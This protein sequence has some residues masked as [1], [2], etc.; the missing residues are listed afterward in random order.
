MTRLDKIKIGLVAFVLLQ[1]GLIAVFYF[2]L[3]LDI[4]MVLLI[5]IL[6][7]VVLILLWQAMKY[8]IEKQEL[9]TSQI[10]GEEA[11]AAFVFGET[12]L[13]SYNDEYVV[14]WMSELFEERG[15]QRVGKKLLVWLPELDYLISGEREQVEVSIEQKV[16]LVSRKEDSQVMFFK[17]ITEMRHYKMSFEQEQLVVGLL[18]LDNY[19]EST[20]YEDE[21]VLASINTSIRQ[22]VVDWCKEHGLLLRRIRN[23]RYMIVLNEKLFSTLVADRF[24]IVDTVRQASSDLDVSITLSMAFARGTRNLQELDE[25]VVQLLELAQS[26]GGDQVAIRKMGEEVKYFGGN[27]EATEKRSRVRVRVMANTLKDLIQKSENIIICGHKES[28][29][30]CMG[31]AL[32]MSRI[33]QGYDKPCCIIAKT[34][35]IEEK[36][37]QVLELNRE[38]INERHLFVTE[39]EAIN[40]L[41]EETLVIMVDH[42]SLGQSNGTHVIE[43]AKKVAIFDHHR[44][45][46]NL[47]IN[48]VLLYIEA[49]A[50]STSE[51]VSEFVPY[52]SNRI[53]I[54]A[55]EANIMYTGIVID[56]TR[57]K[58]RT[59]MRTFEA[60]SMIRSWGADP[61]ESDEYLK[62]SYDE[63]EL[64]SNIMSQCEKYTKGIV[65]APVDKIISRSLMSQVADGLLQVRDVQ[66]SFVIARN[67]EDTI[68]ISARSQGKVNV[69]VIMESMHGGGHLSAAAVQRDGKDVEKLK[70]ELLDCI[71]QYFKEGGKN[72]SDITK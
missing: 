63:F 53:E 20:R 60:A 25:M 10:V 24:S 69:Q 28:D 15:I 67:S 51:L 7:L 9:D 21:H 2:F 22:P 3:K 13:L 30:D 57:F 31:G 61:I 41:R 4:S 34:G 72:E 36:L 50:S 17:D 11:Q 16:Y 56:T 35:G 70:E 42:H 44:R 8:Q 29:F 39:G 47:E 26:R 71:K 1:A 23:D 18:H 68:A 5:F 65:V 43:K 55:L 48:P 52:L 38:E 32:A 64:K 59:G 12:G 46:A 19:E 40:Q 54:N 27:S 33:V 49:G 66:A 45:A 62:D 37:N 58:V 14:T 6:E